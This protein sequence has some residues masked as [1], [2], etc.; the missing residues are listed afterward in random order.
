MVARFL[1]RY[2]PMDSVS[3]TSENQD[4]LDLIRSEPLLGELYVLAGT[5]TLKRDEVSL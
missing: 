4:F 3:N 1:E 5:V 2:S